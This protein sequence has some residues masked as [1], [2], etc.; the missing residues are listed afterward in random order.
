MTP[1]R[2]SELEAWL[3]G[4]DRRRGAYFRAKAAW[5]MLDRATVL[6]AGLAPVARGGGRR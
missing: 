1:L 3:A 2:A 5:S 4:D 6:G